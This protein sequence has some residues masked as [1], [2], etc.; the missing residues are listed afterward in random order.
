M[1]FYIVDAFTQI[2]F[3]GNPAGVVIYDELSKSNMQK[4]AAELRYSETAFIKIVDP[5]TYNINFFT[6]MAEVDLCGHATIAS[7]GALLK[8]GYV[9]DNNTYQMVTKAGRLSI[10]I[11]NSLVIMEQAAPKIR[12]T[13]EDYRKLAEILNIAEEDIGDN[14][15]NL[16]PQLIST[17]LFD[18]IVPIRNKRILN[19]L[20]PD[21]KA[22]TE[23]SKK[24]DISGIHAFTLDGDNY[25]AHCRNFAPIYGID[26][27]AAT[28]T[29][30]GAT[31]YYLHINNVAKELYQNY[32]FLQG[33]KMGRP[34]EIIT[35]IEDG[36]KVLCGG[37]YYVLG[38]GEINL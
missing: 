1:N 22:L 20:S 12:E 29:A 3:G 23:L 35:R 28:G 31:I 6:P 15:F 33:E 7:F 14:N 30:S 25:L 34:S 13:Y 5:S 38:K 16:K 27:E 21:F 2:P 4:I 19:N 37:S 8:D 10:N 17:G 11:K 9:K 26:E 32:T 18:M 24:L 36:E